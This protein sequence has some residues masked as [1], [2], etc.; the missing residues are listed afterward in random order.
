M[1]IFHISSTK[2]ASM[3]KLGP[4]ASDVL[5]ALVS[6]NKNL[7]IEEL[8]EKAKADTLISS[9][10]EEMAISDQELASYINEH[11]KLIKLV[12]KMRGL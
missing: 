2:T 9:E 10:I 4:D 12:N 8:I 7:S 3:G 11:L 1:K 5:E 6:I